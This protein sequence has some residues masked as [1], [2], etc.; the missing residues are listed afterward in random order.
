[1]TGWYRGNLIPCA[2]VAVVAGYLLATHFG[3]ARE[4]AAAAGDRV[5]AVNLATILSAIA[6]PL[7]VLTS[8]LVLRRAIDRLL[9]RLERAFW[10]DKGLTFGEYSPKPPGGKKSDEL[11][12]GLIENGGKAP[13]TSAAVTAGNSGPAIDPSK[14]GNLFWLG[15]DLMFAFD[16]L[17]RG[18]DRGAIANI[19]RQ[20]NHHMKM[21]GLKGAPIQV[22][23]QRLTDEAAKSLEK[24]WTNDRRVEFAREVYSIGREFGETNERL[25]PGF[26]P[27]PQD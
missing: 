18:G 10:G 26:D 14:V 12:K 21:L 4:Y 24:D 11:V 5:T 6:W 1:M 20:A 3:L 2:L 8:V 17:L 13:N 23:L 19:F 9:T 7:V 22:R 27:R 25:Q 15:S 16:T